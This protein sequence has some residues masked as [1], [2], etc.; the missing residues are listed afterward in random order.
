MRRFLDYL[1]YAINLISIPLAIYLYFLA[2]QERVPT[3]YV[4]PE[5]TRII[6]TT[7]PAPSELQVLFKGK[8]LR[9]DVSALIV[10][11]WNDGKPPIE[12]GDVLEPLAIELD[13]ACEILD[14]RLLKVSRPVTKFAKGDLSPTSKNV[15]PISFE[16]L[17]QRDGAAIQIIYTGNPDATARMIGVVVGASQVRAITTKQPRQKTTES[18]VRKRVVGYTLLAL[19]VATILFIVFRLIGRR[20]NREPWDSRDHLY[21]ASIVLYIGMGAYFTYDMYHSL[22]PVVPKTIWTQQ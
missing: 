6:D 20:R 7:V 17:E 13:S 14:A 11:V 16:I 1:S 5:R 9:T 4:S 19:V 3:Y 15:L 18:S 22:E 8:D 12:A 2:V 21:V 10:Y